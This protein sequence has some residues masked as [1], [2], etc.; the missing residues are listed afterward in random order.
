MS[1]ALAVTVQQ[2]DEAVGRLVGWPLPT[3]LG[4]GPTAAASLLLAK[5]GALARYWQGAE[6]GMNVALP[7]VG[8][9]AVSVNVMGSVAVATTFRCVVSVLTVFH[10]A[11]AGVSIRAMLAWL[12]ASAGRYKLTLAMVEGTN[13]LPRESRAQ[14][15]CQQE[16][17]GEAKA[18]AS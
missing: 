13:A 3:G 11:L 10:P 9:L 5:L 18:K 12:F 17:P 8:A 16:P 15:R 4:P 14:G 7:G 1:D 6:L 2:L